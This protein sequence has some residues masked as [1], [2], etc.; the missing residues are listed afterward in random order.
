MVKITLTDLIG[1]NTY[2]LM[3]PKGTPIMYIDKLRSSVGIN[4]IPNND[5]A[6]EVN[7]V[8]TTQLLSHLMAFSYQ[9][10]D[11]FVFE[12]PFEVDASHMGSIMA[13]AGTQVLA[14][15]M[16]STS[17]YINNILSEQLSISLDADNK[18]FTITAQNVVTGVMTILIGI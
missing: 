4:C 7:G 6:L 3:V 2:E 9:N 18:T 15:G 10:T 12:M 16:A 13:F 11:T 5:N 14:F 8:D 17:P 1:S